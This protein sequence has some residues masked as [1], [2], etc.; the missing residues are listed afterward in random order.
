VV[1]SIVWNNVASSGEGPQIYLVGDS[2][3]EPGSLHIRY[4]DVEGGESLVY[5]SGVYAT[6]YWGPGMID[7]DPLFMDPVNGD[8][9]L[10]Q[11]SCQMMPW[12]SQ[13]P[14]VDAGDPA[15]DM[16]RGATR[17]DGVQDDGIVDMGFHYPPYTHS[18]TGLWLEERPE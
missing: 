7:A 18:D 11:A 8:Y 5:L 17:T 12:R 1:D 14:C 9:H 16:V 4:S 2:D 10:R 15:S 3:F 6:L 13:N